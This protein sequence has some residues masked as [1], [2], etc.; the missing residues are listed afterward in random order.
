M[1]LSGPLRAFRH[2]KFLIYWLTGMSA[3]FGWQIQLVGASWLMLSLGASA[4]MIALVQASVAMPVMLLSLPGGAVSDIL[5]QRTVILWSQAFLVAVSS[6][7]AAGAHLGLLTPGLLLLCTFLIGCGRAVYYPGWQSMVLDLVPRREVPQAIGLNASNLNIAR[8][9]GP[10][11]GGAIVSLAGVF[12]A[13]LANAFA[14]LTVIAFVRGWPRKIAGSEVPIETLRGA[15]VAGARFFAFS[16]QLVRISLRACAFNIAA[17]AILALL[18]LVAR[19]FLNGGPEV[20]GALLGAF[21]IGAVAG[22]LLLGRFRCMLALEPALAV[23]YTLFALGAICIALSRLLLLTVAGGVL[24]GIC[25]TFVQVTLN[26]AVQ[27]SSPRWVLSRTTAIYQ[28]IIF[29][30]NALGS[31]T[32]GTLAA[33]PGL[34]FSLLS[35]AGLMIAAALGGRWFRVGE[36]GAALHDGVPHQIEPRPKLALDPFDGPIIATIH[37]RIREG[38]VPLFLQ[39]MQKKRRLRLRDGASRWSLSRDIHEPDLW[40]ERYRVTNWAEA[41]RLHWR[42]TAESVEINKLVLGLHR[43]EDK[44]EVHYTLAYPRSKETDTERE[45]LPSPGI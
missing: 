22:V 26:A 40:F 8:S 9:F 44:L 20:F 35:S 17:V 13:F 6:A 36:P 23:S 18:P 24:C 37:Y 34:E 32:W 31:L 4:Q 19:D 45:E 21:G 11:I 25:W 7:L 42:R 12:V 2:R 10:A 14:N 15:V 38:D 5:G 29:G 30:G 33:T 3:N 43:A 1:M 16:P 41:Q 27:V 28:S 39:A